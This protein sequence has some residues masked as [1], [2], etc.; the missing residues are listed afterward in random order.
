MK[1]QKQKRRRV[2]FTLDA[3]RAE[4]VFLVGDFN[5]W[6]EKK[7]PMKQGAG[8][9]WKKIV[10]VTPGTYQYKFLVDGGWRLDPN[11]PQTCSNSYGTTNNILVIS[12]IG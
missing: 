9:G 6:D 11:N 3:P 4:E 5:G 8:D 1:Q 12:E 2:T 10:Y 7:H